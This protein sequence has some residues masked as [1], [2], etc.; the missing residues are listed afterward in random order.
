MLLQ[1]QPG[2]VHGLAPL[3]GQVILNLPEAGVLPQKDPQLVLDGLRLL[4]HLPHRPAVHIPPQIDHAVLLEQVVI[5]LVLGD[6]PG[7][8]RGL[9]INFN[10][11]LPSAILNE[12]VRKPAVLV[13]VREGILGVEI[14]GFLG[15][16][17]VGEQLDKQVLGTAAGGRMIGEHKNH[18]T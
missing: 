18:L 6:Q 5:E 3:G 7:I 4:L 10:G 12:K 16:E 14:A 8:V 17:G 1:L 9:V 2:A 15:A 11:H 13:D